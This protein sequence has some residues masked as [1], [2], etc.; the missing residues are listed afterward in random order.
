MTNINDELD[1]TVLRF[2]PAKNGK[3]K[4]SAGLLIPIIAF[5]EIK[6]GVKR[7]YLVSGLI[8]R[9]GI[10]VVWGPPKSGNTLNDPTSV[11]CCWFYQNSTTKTGWTAGAG[12]EGAIPSTRD[13]TWK[14]EY[15]YVDLGTV[16]GNGS[17]TFDFVGPFTWSTKFTDNIVRGG[18]NYRF[19]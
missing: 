13:W 6:L 8:P 15:L 9:I 16:S 14:I 4:K 5:N 12:I 10:V 2:D 1:E 11:P 3:G 17:D 18:I 7:R 19:W